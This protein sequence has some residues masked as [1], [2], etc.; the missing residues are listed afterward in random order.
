MKLLFITRK[1][2]TADSR[3]G[4]VIDWLLVLAKH[5]DQLAVVCQEKGDIANLPENIVVYSL[6]KELGHS[7]IRQF[8]Q[9]QKL[10]FQ[11]VKNYDGIFAHQM[12]IYA[13]LAAPA[14]K[15]FH[16]KLIQWY[17]HKSVDWR[18]CL[19]NLLVN[20]FATASS[21]SFRLKTKKP[22]HIFGH[23]INVEK[24]K[25]Q[26]SPIANNEYYHLLTVGRISP[27]KDYESMIKAIYDLREQGIDQLKLT[28]VGAPAMAL[29]FDYFEKLQTLVEKMR[30][31]KQ[32]EFLGGLPPTRIIPYLQNAD[33]FLN[34]SA[35]GS[36]DKAVLEAMACGC[37]VLTSNE[38]F[39]SILP[40]ELFIAKDQPEI[41]AERIKSLMD[42]P[43]DKKEELAKQLRQE[44]VSHHNLADLAKKIIALY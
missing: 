15:I 24:F 36:L 27:S 22:I 2:D 33:L 3:A 20:G 4:F 23:G 5:L 16:K 40:A 31:T 32:V 28:I 12:P 25:N 42:L 34:L 10:L 41:L 44:V 14:G 18:L 29:G 7:K 19:A 35:T 21:E 9:A 11:L 13:V 6:G 39:Q 1:V 38:S 17:T 43:T 26:K 8:F 37:L 30:L